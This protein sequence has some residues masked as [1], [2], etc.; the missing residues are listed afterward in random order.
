MCSFYAVHYG[1]PWQAICILPWT[2]IPIPTYAKLI[3]K[4]KKNHLQR[5]L[6]FLRATRLWTG[7]VA[8]SLI[9]SPLL[10]TRSPGVA[11]RGPQRKLSLPLHM[12]PRW[13]VGGGEWGRGWAST[14]L[15]AAGPED[16]SEG[17]AAP[18]DHN[19]ACRWLVWVLRSLRSPGSLKISCLCGHPESADL[20]QSLP[21]FP[22][23][24]QSRELFRNTGAG[25]VFL[26]HLLHQQP[27]LPEGGGPFPSN[28]VIVST[29]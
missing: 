3:C 21:T 14:M 7:L 9:F 26:F 18:E 20:E 23:H 16:G 8:W 11:E 15:T 24:I 10:E 6:S 27:D 1:F 19:P 4:K 25:R 5:S 22:L 13:E 29:N 28:C 12:E 2:P 17:G